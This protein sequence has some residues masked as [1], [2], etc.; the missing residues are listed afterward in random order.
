LSPNEK[1]LNSD[2][3][4][5]FNIAATLKPNAGQIH[6]GMMEEEIQWNA[7]TRRAHISDYI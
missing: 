2:L 1:V 3:I 5:I 6:K 4:L 7:I